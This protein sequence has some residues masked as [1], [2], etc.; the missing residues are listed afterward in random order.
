[1]PTGAHVKDGS[2]PFQ[3]AI[4]R[5]ILKVIDSGN[6]MTADDIVDRIIQNKCALRYSANIWTML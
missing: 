3:A 5:G 2:N 6:S 1:V 4:D